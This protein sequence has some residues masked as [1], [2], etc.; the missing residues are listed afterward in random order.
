MIS[1]QR[2]LIGKGDCLKSAFVEGALFSLE[3]D[4]LERP[5]REYSEQYS[6]KPS[7]YK[8]QC[9]AQVSQCGI[10]STECHR[11]ILVGSLYGEHAN[12]VSLIIKKKMISIEFADN[13]YV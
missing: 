5:Q 1:H 2:I 12:V 10:Q 3:S 4:S 8:T 9:S 13:T 6:C 7:N 11:H